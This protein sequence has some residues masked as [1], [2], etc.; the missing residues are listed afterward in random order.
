MAVPA[1]ARIGRVVGGTLCLPLP[2]LF[3]DHAD[4]D[5]LILQDA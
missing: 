1:A 4:R 5:Y 3:L 2:D